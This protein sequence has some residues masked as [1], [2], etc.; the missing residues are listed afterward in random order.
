[1]KQPITYTYQEE[2]ELSR[3]DTFLDNMTSYTFILF[4]V[5]AIPVIIHLLRTLLS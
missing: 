4:L 2:Q 5:F 3:L 1:M